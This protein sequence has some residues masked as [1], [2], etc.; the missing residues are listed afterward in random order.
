MNATTYDRMLS[1]YF[2][3]HAIKR[4]PLSDDGCC[5]F[6]WMPEK[7]HW[8]TMGIPAEEKIDYHINY[9]IAFPWFSQVVSF[10][11]S[12]LFLVIP[13]FRLIELFQGLIWGLLPTGKPT[14]VPGLATPIKSTIWFDE[15]TQYVS[16]LCITKYLWVSKI[17]DNITLCIYNIQYTIHCVPVCTA[18]GGSGSFKDRTDRRGSLLWVMDGRANPLMDRKV[19][20]SS[21]V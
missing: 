14:D 7:K 5:T 12:I 3:S 10:C 11:G 18:Q 8:V 1:P 2:Q 19:V 20:G 6:Q 15:H 9:Q 16:W 17:L 4:K 13:Q 21:A